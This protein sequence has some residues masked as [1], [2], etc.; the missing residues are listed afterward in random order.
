MFCISVKDLTKRYGNVIALYNVT[1]NIECNEKW[2]LLG[3][4]G[5]GKSTMLKILAG[6]IKPD[7]GEVRIMDK[8]PSSPEVRKILGYLPEDA[9][10]FPGLSVIDNLKFVAS[11]RDVDESKIY[12]LLDLLDLRQY[13]NYKASTLSRGNRQKLAI[14]MA[15]LHNPSLLLLDEPLNYL[16]IPSQETVIDLFSRLNSTLLVSTHILSVADRLATKVLI[17]SNGTIRWIGDF[18]LLRSMG[19][20]DEPIER[21]VARIIKEGKVF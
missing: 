1:F 17:I 21:I 6:L 14:A 10:P 9:D 7:K 16:D 11:L 3:P 19:K 8:D 15:I 5:A 20:E 4:N 18:S 2:A 12:D 13:M